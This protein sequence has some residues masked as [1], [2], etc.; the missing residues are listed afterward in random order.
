MMLV[1][2]SAVEWKN[3]VVVSSWW[4]DVYS[5][6][7]KPRPLIQQPEVKPNFSPSFNSCH[8]ALHIT[9]FFKQFKFPKMPFPCDSFS[10]MYCSLPEWN[11]QYLCLNFHQKSTRKMHSEQWGKCLFASWLTASRSFMWLQFCKSNTTESL[12]DTGLS[13]TCVLNFNWTSY[14]TK[15]RIKSW[16]ASGLTI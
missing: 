9:I 16:S 7:K 6:L 5:P 2:H 3:V 4:C 8:L 14:R 11:L 15:K 13:L 1:G 10:R 12:L